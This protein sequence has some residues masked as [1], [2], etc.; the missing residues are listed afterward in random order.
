MRLSALNIHP[1]K[2]TAIR[3][4]SEAYVGRAGLRGD[5]EWMVVDATGKLVSARELSS[6][7]EVVAD[8]P[9]TDP[10]V[11]G[12]LRLRHTGM[13]DLALD[14]PVPQQVPVVLH[15]K[16]LL[17]TPMGEAADEWLQRAV[18][19]AGVRL[20][21]CDDPTRR[22]LNPD[23]AEPGDHVA[24]ADSSPLSLASTT[25]V[26]QLNDWVAETALDLGE[27]APEPLPVQRFRANVVI[28]GVDE[29][30]A[31]D[32][33]R[34]VRIG[35]VTF[36]MPKPIDRCVMTTVD[37]T[38]LDR[39]KEPI[40]TLARHRR[41]DGKTWFAVKLVPDTEGTIRVGDELTVLD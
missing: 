2:S 8:T 3:P 39:G 12:A 21:W 19:R 15:K 34:R 24:F 22:G 16:D 31:E 13:P 30:F 38:T 33:W 1:V 23:Y 4:V 14:L 40:R 27:T 5:R 29:A 37:P 28:D 9:A 7:F 26:R 6:L 11:A 25:S 32:G 10:T 18:G 35:D 36:R 41:W 17:A 20:M